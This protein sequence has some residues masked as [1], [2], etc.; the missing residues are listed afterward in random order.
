MTRR[1]RI[2]AALRALAPKIPRHELG[3]VLD[4][5][6]TSP[7]LRKAAPDNAA[8]LSLVAYARHVFTE[9]DELLAS[10]YDHDSARHFVAGEIEAVLVRWGVRRRLGTDEDAP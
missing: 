7:G 10:G 8:W 1:A 4:H 2:E 3:A 9:Y 5:A 6:E